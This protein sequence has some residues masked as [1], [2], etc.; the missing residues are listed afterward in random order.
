M[1]K[2]ILKI[3]LRHKSMYVKEY[4]LVN[5]K[6]GN[7][8]TSFIKDAILF[9]AQEMNLIEDYIKPSDFDIDTPLEI[10]EVLVNE[11]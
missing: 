9:T 8:L 6:D 1:K 3:S 4:S 2:Y 5:K 7:R 11:D 10:V